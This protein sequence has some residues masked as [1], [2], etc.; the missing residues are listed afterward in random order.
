MSEIVYPNPFTS[1]ERNAELVAND[2]IGILL[3]NT[4]NSITP[5]TIDA[6]DDEIIGTEYL[7]VNVSEE[8][9]KKWGMTHPAWRFVIKS[10]DGSLFANKMDGNKLDI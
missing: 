7:C 5:M 6:S 1:D 10:I 4:D 2:K 3:I 9:H 8:T